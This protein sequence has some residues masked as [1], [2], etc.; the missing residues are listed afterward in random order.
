MKFCNNFGHLEKLDTLILQQ[1]DM[2]HVRYSI[3]YIVLHSPHQNKKQ[4]IHSLACKVASCEEEQRDLSTHKYTHLCMCMH[5]RIE[6]GTN[7]H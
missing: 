5:A 2:S 1:F 6:K 4:N 7:S 3:Q